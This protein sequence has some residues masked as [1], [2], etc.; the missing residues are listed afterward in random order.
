[1][2][3]FPEGRRRARHTARISL[4]HSIAWRLC[5][6]AAVTLHPDKACIQ[7]RPQNLLSMNGSIRPDTHHYQLVI[8]ALLPQEPRANNSLSTDSSTHFNAVSRA[9]IGSLRCSSQKLQ[10][11]FISSQMLSLT[12]RIKKLFPSVLGCF[13]GPQGSCLLS[14]LPLF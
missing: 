8:A 10:S 2:A 9:T 12:C 13:H 3:P 1:M 4:G 14:L 7:K 6:D 5:V 11:C